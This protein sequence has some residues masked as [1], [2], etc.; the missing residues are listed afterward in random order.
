MKLPTLRDLARQLRET[1]EAYTH[2][3]CGGEYVQI[4]CGDDRW[5][6]DPVGFWPE[7]RAFGREYVPGDECP[8]ARQVAWAITPRSG[9][10]VPVM[11]R[12]TFDALAAARRLLAAARDAGFR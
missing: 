9:V 7:R 1:H 2:P 5:T 3:D 10:P 4:P 6:I 12:C 8:C 11:G